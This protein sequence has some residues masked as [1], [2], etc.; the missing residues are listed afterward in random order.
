MTNLP[1]VAGLW[2]T[3]RPKSCMRCTNS[4][5]PLAREQGKG[6]PLLK[7]GLRGCTHYCCLSDPLSVDET[8]RQKHQARSPTPILWYVNLH[9]GAWLEPWPPLPPATYRYVT[10]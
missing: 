8:M 5:S 4:A 2:T 7:D 10:S 9:T 1:P 3:C 6:P